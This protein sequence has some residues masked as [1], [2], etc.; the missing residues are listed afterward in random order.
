MS[1]I[2]IIPA[3]GGSKR[4]QKKN[5]KPFLGKPI[6]AYSIEAA[7]NSNLFDEVMVSTDD[8]EIEEVALRFGAK[9]P[10]L[11]SKKNS[12]DFSG[13]VDVIIEVLKNYNIADNENHNICCLYPTAP[14][15]TIDSIKSALELLVDKKYDTVFPVTKFSYPIQRALKIAE[16]QK[17]SM[18]W[19]ENM[20]KRSQDLPS[21][22]HDAGQFYWMTSNS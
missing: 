2:C 11:R 4:I 12:D 20:S 22:Y 21:S 3:R 16:N 1:N 10:F 19:P 6:I 8:K 14:M 7:I 9:V 5:I 15:V 17:V 13:T 18:I